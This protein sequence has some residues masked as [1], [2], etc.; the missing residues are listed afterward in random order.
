MTVPKISPLSE[1]DIAHLAD[2]IERRQGEADRRHGLESTWQSVLRSE[3]VRWVVGLAVAG[4][5]SYLTTIATMDKS[6]TNVTTTE[7]NHFQEVL[8]RLDLMQADIRELRK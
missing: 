2:V 6:V 3:A 4:A 1:D 5:L 8:R 7:N